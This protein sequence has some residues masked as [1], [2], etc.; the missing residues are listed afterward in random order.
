[1]YTADQFTEYVYSAFVKNRSD[2]GFEIVA[3]LQIRAS[4]AENSTVIY[5]DNLYKSYQ[6]DPSDVDEQIAH[7]INAFPL[8][9]EEDD[10][11]DPAAIVPVVKDIGFL[12]EI[13]QLIEEQ[14]GDEGEQ[15]SAV[16]QEYNEKLVI[17][18]AIDSEQGI[19]Y[20]FDD[21]LAGLGLP[22]DDLLPLAVENLGNLLPEIDL[23][24]QDGL[25]M[26]TAGGN[27]EASLLLL[28]SIWTKDNF[29]VQGS[30]VISIPSRDVLL[31]TGTE[32]TEGLS[33]IKEYAASVYE[34]ASY[35]ILPDLFVW[36]GERFISSE[37]L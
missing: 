1:M 20:L 32:E 23:H 7:F 24:F 30:I 8:Q 34:S 27:Y 4:D 10:A 29:P 3:E 33:K 6:L 35:R 37:G 21:T 14:Q 31:V 17:L 5:L 2:L 16:Y 11:I 13:A 9:E 25:Y 36:N 18:F 26:I 28:D 19:S 12:D 22:A 15:V